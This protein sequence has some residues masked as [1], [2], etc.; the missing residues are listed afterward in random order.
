VKADN[1][2]A[3]C[4]ELKL[5]IVTFFVPLWLFDESKELHNGEKKMEL[6]NNSVAW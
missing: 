1:V 6:Q 2:H 4:E 3:V 5:I